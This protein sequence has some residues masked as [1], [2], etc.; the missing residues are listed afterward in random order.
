M[1]ELAQ[2]VTQRQAEIEGIA[3][4]KALAETEAQESRR[5]IERLHGERE[6]VS[7]QTAELQGQ[8]TTQESDIAFREEALREQRKQHTDLQQHRGQLDVEL[9]QKNMA[10]QNL[11]DRVQQK[12]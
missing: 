10:V 4:R 11:R 6:V 7:K 8:K 1:V 5:Q 9:A 3:G 2:V 12:Y